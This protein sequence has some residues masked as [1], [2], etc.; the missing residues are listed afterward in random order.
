LA[1]CFSLAWAPAPQLHPV[2]PLVRSLK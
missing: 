1:I 2:A